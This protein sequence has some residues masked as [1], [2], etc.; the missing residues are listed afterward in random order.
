MRAKSNKIVNKLVNNTH[1]F[2]KHIL[3]HLK[4]SLQLTDNQPCKIIAL[5]VGFRA[6]ALRFFVVLLCDFV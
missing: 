5:N 4:K 1:Y 3:P 2:S 6:V